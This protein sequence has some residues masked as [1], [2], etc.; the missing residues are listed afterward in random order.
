D[1]AFQEHRQQA[2]DEDVISP[3][4]KRIGQPVLAGVKSEVKDQAMDIDQHDGG[5]QDVRQPSKLLMKCDEHAGPQ[6]IE[7]FFDGQRPRVLSGVSDVW[8]QGETV[9][10][11]VKEG[12]QVVVE[13]GSIRPSDGKPTRGER[14]DQQDIEG[15]K[16]AEDTPNI[17]VAYG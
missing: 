11:G 2:A 16:D 7:L 15:G 1:A 12:A 4:V 9:I 3:R 17:E 8:S 13:Q 10:N 6:K 5:N 14:D